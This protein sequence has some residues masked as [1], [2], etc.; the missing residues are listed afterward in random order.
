MDQKDHLVNLDHLVQRDLWDPREKVEALACQDPQD[1]Q[2]T[3][4]HLVTYPR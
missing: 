2:E 3:E 4:D 1:L